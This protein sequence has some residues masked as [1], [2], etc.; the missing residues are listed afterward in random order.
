MD[1]EILAALDDTK[2]DSNGRQI[3]S[4]PFSPPSLSASQY[5]QLE[6]LQHL[7]LYS[8]LLILFS[9]EKGMGKTFLANSL[10]ASREAPDQSLMVDCD[11][12]LSYLDILHKI[13][14][15]FDLA[16][17]EEV[18]RL[19]SQILQYCEQLLEDEQGSFLLVLDQAE[20]LSSETLLHINQL[21]LILPSVF[22]V[23]L[24]AIPNIE[25][26][27]LSL[28]E[29]HAPLHIM[30]VDALSEDDGEVILLQQFPEKEWAADEV[31]YILSQSKGNVG[32]LLYLAGQI[33]SGI[34]PASVK[35]S[36]KF[37]ITHIAAIVLIT[38]AFVMSFLYQNEQADET[39][40]SSEIVD[41]LASNSTPAITDAANNSSHQIAEDESFAADESEQEI[42]FN[43]I[44]PM[45]VTSVSAP[46]DTA[47]E[48]ASPVEVISPASNTQSS[49]NITK[50]TNS[51]TIKTTNVLSSAAS[52]TS[53]T[54]SES[55]LLAAPASS[56]I[57]QLF[58]SY[59]E[60]NAQAFIQEHANTGSTL[61]YY[62][63]E[64]KGKAWFVVVSGPYASKTVA[65]ESAAKLPAGLRKQNPWV[66]SIKPI[67]Q[68][69]SAR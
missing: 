26:T 42:D 2:H 52:A 62:R 9:G 39:I 54:S 46:Q 1:T 56:F 14:Q 57:A 17:I 61:L 24:L 31:D 21:A 36:A 34:A 18:E 51:D 4:G 25:E 28:P 45:K 12:S 30:D 11:F 68:V 23:I 29:P 20:Q 69:L 41:V 40:I 37:P 16:E 43:F 3:S 55:Q 65:K 47:K 67:Q 35:V 38:S 7:A 49:A 53:L 22:H 5:K 44:E 10:I 64:H 58:G 15:H 6:L 48:I 63:T 8:E 32:K 60:K 50:T 59:S 13:A 19:E 66:R 27:L 33:A